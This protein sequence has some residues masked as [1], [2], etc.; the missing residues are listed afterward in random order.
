[1]AEAA[2]LIWC[3]FWKSHVKMD[4]WDYNYVI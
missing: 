3:V 4:T 1:M 2:A